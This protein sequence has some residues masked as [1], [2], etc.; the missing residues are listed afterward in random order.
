MEHTIVV[1]ATASESAAL[2]YIAP[3]GGCAMGEYFRDLGEDALIIYDDLTKQ[4]WAYRQV[5]LLLKRPPGREAYPGDVFYLHSRLLERASRINEEYVEKITNGK[6]KGKTGSLTALPIIET[7]AGDV[8]AF[9]PTN[10][11]SITDGQIFLESDLFNAGFRPAINAGL[12]VSRVGGAAQTKII[13]KLGGGIRLALA[14]YRELAAFAQFASDLDEATRKQLE[15]GQRVMELMKQKQYSPLNVAEMG[16]SL[17]AVENGFLD[18]IELEKIG[19]FEEALHDYMK[20]E[21]STLID[22]IGVE[23]NYDDEIETELNSA[24]DNF[25]K[26]NTW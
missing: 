1:A 19:A 2:Q 8:S 15:R 5:S 7:Q 16:V 9:V 21:Q 26:N 6:V 13:K 11:I 24:I 14:Q 12:S 20:S 18:D 17:F 23:G 25:K 4:A 22:K 10:V 3:Y